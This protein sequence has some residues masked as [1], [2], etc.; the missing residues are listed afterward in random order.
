[1]L[2]NCAQ[3][4]SVICEAYELQGPHFFVLPDI[5]QGDRVPD[6]VK[7]SCRMCGQVRSFRNIWFAKRPKFR[8]GRYGAPKHRKV[9]A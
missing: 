6:I 8:A 3:S 4:Q 1:M 7:S 9:V 5:I 2:N